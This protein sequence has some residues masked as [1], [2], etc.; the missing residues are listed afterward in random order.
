MPGT[1]P[2]MFRLRRASLP[3]TLSGVP[4][5]SATPLRTHRAL[6]FALMSALVVIGIALAFVVGGGGKRSDR[7]GNPVHTYTPSAWIYLVIV[8]IGLIAA[9]VVQFLGYRFPAISPNADP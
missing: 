5:A 4:A 8:L 9:V 7:Q 3:L 1:S 2:G 6:A